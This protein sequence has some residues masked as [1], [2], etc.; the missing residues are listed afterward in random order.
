[1][2]LT[3]PRLCL[4]P[5]ML[6]A[7]LLI[8]CCA[9]DSQ[10]TLLHRNASQVW[11]TSSGLPQD[12]VHQLLQ[13]QDGF[14]W[15]ATEGG[16]VR[17]DGYDFAVYDKGSAPAAFSGDLVNGL[18]E[19]NTSHLWVATSDGLLERGP[20]GGTG[21]AFRRYTVQ[22][23]LPSATVWGIGQ[24]HAGHI[25]AVTSSGIARLDANKFQPYNISGIFDGRLQQ[26]FVTGAD[27]TLW[28]ASATSLTSIDPHGNI[29][30][31]ALPAAPVDIAVSPDMSLWVATS[32]SLLRVD[33]SGAVTTPSLPSAMGQAKLQ[34]LAWDS[35]KALWIGTTAGLYTSQSP[36]WMRPAWRHYG[37]ADGLPGESITKIH[38]AGNGILSLVT[39]AGLAVY[40]G[41]R[42]TNSFEQDGFRGTDVLSLFADREGDL[43]LGS[44]NAGTAI[45]RQLPFATLGAREGLPTDPVRSLQ[46]GGSGDMWL[47][48]AA[49]LS[50]FQTLDSRFSTFTTAQGLAS[51]EILALAPAAQ[52]GRLWVGTPDGLSYL[53]HGRATTLTASDGLP[54]D[55]IR[56]LLMARD[57]TLWIGTSHGLASLAPTEAAVKAASIRTYTQADGLGSNVIGALL[58][59]PDGSLWIGTLNGLGHLTQGRIRNY[60]AKDGLT[61]SIVTALA[62]DQGRLWIGTRGGGLFILDHGAILV[63]GSAADYASGRLPS[64]I[65][66]IVED[67]SA[68]LWLSS[69]TGIYRIASTDLQAM[70]GG[71]RKAADMRVDHFDVSDGLRLQDCAS[72]G[73][74]EAALG[75][76]GL[77]W[78]ATQKGAS[79]VDT[80]NRLDRAAPP[81][82]I[83]NITV[84][85]AAIAPEHG[86]F[87][88]PAGHARL[89]FHYAGVSLATP[90]K[91]RYRYQLEHFDRD[92][93][94][95]GAR[96]TAYYTN[97]PPGHYIFRVLAS[98][99][100]G[101]GAEA[102]S[103]T[104]ATI[105]FTIAPHYYQTWWFYTLLVLLL[106]LIAWQLYLYRLRQVELRFDAVLIERGR[107]ARE[108][109]DTLAQDI[110]GISVQLE[111]VSRLMTLSV[112]K[113]MAQLKETRSLVRKSLEQARS[114]IWELRSSS[115]GDLPTRLRDAAQQITRDSGI[116][117]RLNIGG[118]YRAF[119]QATEDELLRIA[120]EAIT[121]AVRHASPKNIEVTMN[122]HAGGA[123]LQV[124]DDGR[125]FIVNE[126]KSG[127]AGHF[128]I[129]GMH[130]RAQRARATLDIKSS[131]GEGTTV[132]AE[133]AQG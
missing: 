55:N 66:A 15:L 56:S 25:W 87:Q 105:E 83:E 111:L 45:V 122:Y 125:G 89:A 34:S 43:W 124:Q 81:V 35:A 116:A 117:L 47:G 77:L 68:H 123:R 112:D 32:H 100:G 9:L 109:H 38:A 26:P 121:N 27:G 33:R 78:F 104:A 11:N 16:L 80:H 71:Q 19:D 48:T 10:S 88:I 4:R 17:F 94:A 36:A 79:V 6:V 127:P 46:G 115:T 49:G 28:I 85:D 70:I 13:T 106:A 97:I 58:E 129:R 7:V 61:S 62:R 67:D 133:A 130:E 101:D 50:H 114:S 76:D 102:W 21:S 91:V 93:I 3:Y 1:M 126:T 29:D 23:G 108:I 95:A 59:D 119:P 131:P 31:L 57:K 22:D 8:S 63:V 60:S 98:L 110:V 12:T 128:G 30:T 54:D 90:A 52:A 82:S 18:F 69:S 51:N 132:I 74:P 99:N 37:K 24:D 65:Y 118:T 39:D 20:P 92:W 73:H 5:L 53:D 113:A 41:G 72:G 2:M 107:I 44:A 14:L 64:T 84:D 120:Q 86:A 75:T 103:A 40:R 96:R 42:F